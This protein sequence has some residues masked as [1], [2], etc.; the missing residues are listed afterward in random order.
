MPETDGSQT[1]GESHAGERTKQRREG[2]AGTNA[3][4]GEAEI[5]SGHPLLGRPGDESL[6]PLDPRRYARHRV[7]WVS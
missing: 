7:I 4:D 6:E 2:T 1:P 3:G 5:L